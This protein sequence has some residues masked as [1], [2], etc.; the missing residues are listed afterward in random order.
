MTLD[1]SGCTNQRDL[2]GLPTPAG[3]RIRSGALVRSGRH[4]GLSAATIAAIR[5]GAVGRIIDLRWA[6]ECAEHPS[7]FAGDA[8]YRHVPMLSDV[9]DYDPPPDSYGPML[10]HC[11]HR[12]GHAFRAVAEA[13]PGAVVVHCHAGKDRTGVLVALLLGVAG[14]GPDDIAADYA[15][16]DGSAAQTMLNTLAH[17]DHHYGGLLPYLREIGVDAAGVQATRQRLLG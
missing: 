17:L 7:P 5:A 9:L 6:W 11:Q 12:I 14:V 16:T 2:G 3:G 4:D 13:P 8:V 10:D 1:W 15:R